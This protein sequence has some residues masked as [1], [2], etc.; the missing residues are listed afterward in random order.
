MRECDELPGS[1]NEVF[2]GALSSD[3][4]PASA[5]P[6][7]GSFWSEDE[8]PYCNV[9]FEED[10]Y[11]HVKNAISPEMCA[12]LAQYA[13]RERTMKFRPEAKWQQV[14]GSHSVY[15]DNRME[16]L[17]FKLKPMMEHYTKKRL[18]PTYSYYRVYKSGDILPTHTDREACQYSTTITLGYKYIDKPDDG[19]K[20][21][22]YVIADNKKKYLDFVTGDAII[23]KGMEL[24]HGRDRFD[25]GEQ[26]WQVAVFLHYVD[27]DGPFK[28]LKYDSN[29]G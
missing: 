23:Y 4:T 7:K 17:L 18:F 1:S 29:R 2:E 25:V 6:K 13:L 9:N 3:T 22:L 16:S 21:R 11:A 5:C 15:K 20:W 12:I 8:T 24:E 27:A 28:R 19:Y 14:P 26:S 10:K